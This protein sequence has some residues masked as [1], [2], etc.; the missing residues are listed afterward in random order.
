[1][2]LTLFGDVDPP[3]AVPA[4]AR[5]SLGV[6]PVSPD[7]AAVDL[8]AGAGAA[9]SSGPPFSFGIAAA[10]NRAVEGSYRVG[11]SY[12]VL[13]AGGRS[14]KS[15][16]APLAP[17]AV[18]LDYSAPRIALTTQPA[19]TQPVAVQA[20]KMDYPL[21]GVFKIGDVVPISRLPGGHVAGADVCRGQ[22]YHG[23]VQIDGKGPFYQDP[24]PGACGYGL[25]V[26][27]L[28]YLDLKLAGT[29]TERVLAS[30]TATLYRAVDACDTGPGGNDVP[31]P[32]G[33]DPGQSPTP[34]IPLLGAAV[35]TVRT[36]EA[37][38]RLYTP[39]LSGSALYCLAVDAAD[40]A[41]DA[42]GQLSPNRSRTTIPFVIQ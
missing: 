42:I 26:N 40:D 24:N 25:V 16:F 6:A 15:R 32:I 7:A 28:P 38:F 30:A 29:I 36:F 22:H 8:G 37:V 27:T 9:A 18:G 11:D 23:S 1:M 12:D 3:Y 33:T 14:L 4:V 21:G 10:R 39:V 19:A 13:D 34:V 20:V 17:L 41:G 2:V 31:V 35:T 5:A